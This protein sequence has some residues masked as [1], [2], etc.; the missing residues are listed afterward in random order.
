MPELRVGDPVRV[1]SGEFA[2][3]KGVVKFIL[4]EDQLPPL[5]WQPQSERPQNIAVK[6]HNVANVVPFREDELE[7]IEEGK[8]K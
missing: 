8:L 2:G 5:M 6:L 4:R 3:D 7:R 1:L